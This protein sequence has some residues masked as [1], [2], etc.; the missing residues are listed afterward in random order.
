MVRPPER[1]N[2]TEDENLKA[3]ELA[4]EHGSLRTAVQK[5]ILRVYT[6]SRHSGPVFTTLE[7]AKDL[8]LNRNHV[9]SGMQNWTNEAW[10]L[11]H[12]NKTHYYLQRR[13][14]EAPPLKEE[15]HGP[16]DLNKIPAYVLESYEDGG[17]LV[18]IEGQ[19]FY[20]KPAR[21]NVGQDD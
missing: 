12:Q 20:A 13:V 6:D 2:A 18:W 10:S 14:R 11:E 19:L 17:K 21:L 4:E 3:M 1:K 15:E 7:I 16:P 8:G 5:H 9:S